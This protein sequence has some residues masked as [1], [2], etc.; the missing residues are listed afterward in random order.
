[1]T[2]D[3]INSECKIC[4]LILKRKRQ[5]LYLLFEELIV[6]KF[7]LEKNSP[8]KLKI[9]SRVCPIIV[10]NIFRTNL[11]KKLKM[12]FRGPFQGKLDMCQEYWWVQDYYG[13]VTYNVST[14][15]MTIC[16]YIYIYIYI[17][18]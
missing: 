14:M 17:Y 13:S 2:F 4:V 3:I 11:R 16:I 9:G 8:K 15:Y 7:F 12:T 10:I 1:M 5:M 18:M 6:Q